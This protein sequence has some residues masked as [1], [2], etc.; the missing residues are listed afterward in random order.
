MNPLAA[1]LGLLLLGAGL[2]FFIPAIGIVLGVIGFIGIA[3]G[4]M[5]SILKK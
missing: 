1:G 3:W 4:A 2:F 5:T